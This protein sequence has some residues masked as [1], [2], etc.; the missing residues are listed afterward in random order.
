M[1]RFFLL[2]LSLVLLFSSALAATQQPEETW[3][4][5]KCGQESTGSV[6]VV[7]GETRG[8]WTCSNCGA[9]NLS[10]ACM[11]CG[12]EKTASLTQEADDSQMPAAFTAVHYLAA[13]GDP[14]Y[15]TRLGRYYEKGIGVVQDSEKAVDCFRKAGSAGYAPGWLYLGRLYDAGV[16]VDQDYTLGFDW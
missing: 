16:A 6:C 15:L 3:V 12:T 7:C 5:L 9:R 14:V 11:N 2:F 13:A 10:D 4:C 1:K 8:V